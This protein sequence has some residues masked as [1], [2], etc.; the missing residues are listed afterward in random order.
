VDREAKFDQ[1][2]EEIRQAFKMKKIDG[3]QLRKAVEALELEQATIESV[4]ETLETMPYQTIMQ[5]DEGEDEVEDQVLE[6]MKV[7]VIAP[8]SS[9]HKG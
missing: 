2:A 7:K 5:N 3:K 9:K 6:L 8:S 1:R 4:A